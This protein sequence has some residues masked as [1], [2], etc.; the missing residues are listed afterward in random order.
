MEVAK[1]KN[2]SVIQ[3]KPS[4]VSRSIPAIRQFLKKRSIATTVEEESG[5]NAFEVEKPSSRQEYRQQKKGYPILPPFAYGIKKATARL[6]Q[7]VKDSV[8]FL[9]MLISC[10]PG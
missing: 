4:C 1:R 5:G 6:E 7:C 3:T 2:E 8:I 10:P 9:P